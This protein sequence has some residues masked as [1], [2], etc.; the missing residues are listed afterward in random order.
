M[1]PNEKID[2]T[3]IEASDTGNIPGEQ[4]EPAEDS[5]ESESNDGNNED[6]KPKDA[7]QPEEEQDNMIYLE[8]LDYF[9]SS[10]SSGNAFSYYE[11]AKDNL[12][13]TYGN[14]IGGC[15]SR[16]KLARI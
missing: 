16:R 15:R 1:I 4:D 7:S 13:F 3:Q 2:E 6:K 11:S 9:N 14:G 8:K 5:T 12:G 10:N